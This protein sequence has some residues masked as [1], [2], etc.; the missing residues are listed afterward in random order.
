VEEIKM[1]EQGN[2]PVKESLKGFAKGWVI[3]MLVYCFAAAG[4]LLQYFG[5][6]G[7]SGTAN[8][9][10]IL[11]FIGG[12]AAGLV[13]MLKKRALGFWILLASSILL[14]MMRGSSFS[15]YSVSQAGGLVLVFLTWLFTQKQINYKF[16]GKQSDGVKPVEVPPTPQE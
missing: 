3:F 9:L 2:T 14:A 12:M 1:S 7:G 11:L 10:L 16:W 15:G 5:R 13:I 8:L 6:A 4:S